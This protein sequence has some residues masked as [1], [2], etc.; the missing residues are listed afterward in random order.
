MRAIDVRHQGREHVICAWQVDDVIVDPGPESSVDALLDALGDEQPRALLL[1]HI[2][3]DHAGA[4]GALVRDWPDLEVWVHERGAPHLADPRRLVASAK[5]LYGDEFDRLWGEV[6]PI[7]QANLRVL[8]GGESR[9]GWDV[10]YTPGHASHHVS[11]RHQDS[12]WVFA[13]DAAGVRLPPGALLLAPTP[14][15][16]FDLAAWRSSIDTIEAWEPQALAITHFG[17]YADVAEHLDRLREA[18]TRWSELAGR[19]DR[20]GYAA[21]L[22]AELNAT[23]G[24]HDA[25]SF[26]QAIPPEDQ[27]LG[28]D[29]YLSRL[30]EA[31]ATG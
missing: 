1:T 19:T 12:G 31:G 26:V 5:R 27:W 30:R 11:Y 21:A 15:P 7:P 18:L 20:A 14:P 24:E 25:A 2:H 13:G 3:F 6:V 4:A 22:R 9:E 17:D 23:V 8:R 28:I 16:D 29:R 10:A